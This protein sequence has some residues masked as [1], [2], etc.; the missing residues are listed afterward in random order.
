MLTVVNVHVTDRTDWR[1][2]KKLVIS[3]IIR[4][5]PTWQH[6]AT[7][8]IWLDDV[9]S[10]YSIAGIVWQSVPPPG[11]KTQHAELSAELSLDT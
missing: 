2:T 6:S 7:I 10:Q 3:P 5:F 1:Y 8:F 4:F 9:I 11:Q